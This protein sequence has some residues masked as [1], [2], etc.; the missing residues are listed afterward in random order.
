MIH[1]KA[2]ETPTLDLI[3]K[4]LAAVEEPAEADYT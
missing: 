1:A 3:K 2:I 4:L